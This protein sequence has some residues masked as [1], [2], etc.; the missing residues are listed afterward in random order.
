MAMTRSHEGLRHRLTR[1]TLLG[2]V[3]VAGACVDAPSLTSADDLSDPLAETFDALARESALNGDLA[4]SEGF[5]LAALSIRGGVAPSRLEVVSGAITEVYDAFV[6]GVVWD[7][8]LPEATRPPPRRS[9]VGWRRTAEGT[10]RVLSMHAP[11]DSAVVAS[12]VV[13]G[14]ASNSMV[15]FHSASAM[16]NEGRDTPQGR[17]DLSAGWYA[18]SGWVKLREVAVL[19]ACPDSARRNALLG[20][21]LCE[22]TRYLARFDLHMQRLT[23]R[24]P[25]VVPGTPARRVYAVGEPVINGLRIRLACAAPSSVHGCR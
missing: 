7:A 3:L 22:E 1:W 20:F 5:G 11:N 19:G 2:A 17:P 25:Q 8:T 10:T 14:N 18:T 23:G 13:L 15:V 6:S 24:P 12:P 16:Q 21:K 4:R 9:L